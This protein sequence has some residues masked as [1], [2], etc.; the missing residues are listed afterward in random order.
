MEERKIKDEMKGE[1]LQS[2]NNERKERKDEKRGVET[3]GS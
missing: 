1:R 2:L 3:L